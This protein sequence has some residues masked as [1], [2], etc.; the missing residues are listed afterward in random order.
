MTR[1][2]HVVGAGVAGLAA[3]V[4][5]VA[6]GCDVHLHEGAPQAGGRCRTVTPPDGFAHD[7]GTHVLLAANRRALAF[8]EAVGARGDWV[9]P[10]PEGLPI[11]DARTGALH[12]VGLSPWSWLS[13]ARRPPGLGAADLPRLLRL[14]LP[15]PDRPIGA[16]VGDRPIRETLIEPLTVAVLN[17]PVDSASARRLGRALRRMIRPGSARLL[18]ARHGLGPDLVEP[19][20]RLLRARGATV[21]TG[22]RLREIATE[23][24]RA[25]ALRF[26]DGTVAL[27]DGDA[28]ILALP[29]A[30]AKRLLPDLPVPERFE[31]IVNAHYRASLTDRPRFVGLLGTLSQWVLA[32]P[33]H[34]SVTVSAAGAAAEENPDALAGR[35]WGE[36]A[37][38][39]AAVGLSVEAG[40]MPEARVVKEKRATVR[41]GA[42]DSWTPP[43]RPLANLALAG[44]WLTPLPATIESAVISG[45]RAVGLLGGRVVGQAGASRAGAASLAASR[46]S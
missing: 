38:A 32:R 37:P 45:E 5:A 23:G 36:I 40:P 7:N 15:F 35:I 42:G 19:A 46:P 10:E 6:A 26:A 21:R 25:V 43:L 34:V 3:A 4:R 41:Q 28:V 39:L 2:V 30:E 8:L 12:H 11:F 17:T 31:P 29:P 9:E 20:L 1:R 24:G 44:D 14:A 16:V 18:V 27:G 22:A 33:D 13:P